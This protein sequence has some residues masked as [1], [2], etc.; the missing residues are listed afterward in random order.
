MKAL[1]RAQQALLEATIHRRIWLARPDEWFLRGAY[2]QASSYGEDSITLT[3][4]LMELFAPS[5][6]ANFVLPDALQAPRRQ[7]WPRQGFA[8]EDD[9]V[10]YVRSRLVP[11]LDQFPTMR[12]VAEGVLAS[13][14]ADPYAFEVAHA[15]MLLEGDLGGAE[16]AL[17]RLEAALDKHRPPWGPEILARS[18]ALHELALR[19]PKSAKEA[20]AATR[21][22]LLSQLR[23]AQR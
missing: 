8:A 21:S 20:M 23:L 5:P 10:N 6:D 11:W 14:T 4:F 18:Q 1:R 9:L 17:K 3:P 12:S 15:A 16:T 7:S 13:R 19:S 2:L 22:Q